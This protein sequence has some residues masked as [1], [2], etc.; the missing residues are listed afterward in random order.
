MDFPQEY[1]IKLDGQEFLLGRLV[2]NLLKNV[3]WV[4]VDII[5]KESRKIWAHVGDLHG[6]LELDEA[7]HKAVQMLAD[8]TKAKQ[9]N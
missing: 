3:Y 1:F 9:A 5:Q 7:I 8:Y 2:V 6:I 4:E